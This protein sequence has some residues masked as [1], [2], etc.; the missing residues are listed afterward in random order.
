M[1]QSKTLILFCS[2]LVICVFSAPL[3]GDEDDE[4][5]VE[6]NNEELSADSENSTVSRSASNPTNKWPMTDQKP[7]RVIVP[8]VI[9]EKDYTNEALENFRAGLQDIEEKTCVRFVDRL[10]H[11]KDF[12]FVHDNGKGKCCSRIGKG[13]GKQSL[14]LTNSCMLVRKK[15]VHEVIHALGFHHMHQ[16]YDRDNAITIK[17]ENI[18]ETK[19][20]FFKK[21]DNE[22][23]AYNTPYDVLSC[24]HYGKNGFTKNG[25]MTIETKDPK[26]ENEIGKQFTLSDGDAQRIVR[27]YKCPGQYWNSLRQ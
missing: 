21:L 26:F 27:M 2:L 19:I 15:C 4:D 1:V 18:E 7:Y 16:R 5:D 14:K 10:P 22:W 11:H 12:I 13:G 8:I 23:E 25:Q 24:M 20:P 6:L 3:D 9:R 17:W